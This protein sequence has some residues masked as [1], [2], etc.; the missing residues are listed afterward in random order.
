MIDYEIEAAAKGLGI[1]ATELTTKANDLGLALGVKDLSTCV[2]LLRGYFDA[3]RRQKALGTIHKPGLTLKQMREEL[4]KLERALH[5]IV[6]DRGTTEAAHKSIANALKEIPAELMGQLETIDVN[7]K[8]MPYDSPDGALKR[9]LERLPN[10]DT[11]TQKTIAKRLLDTVKAALDDLVIPG[12]GNARKQA[13]P[14]IAGIQC[15]ITHFQETL[16]DRQISETDD[17][18]FSRYVALW[19]QKKK[20]DDK[21]DKL[22]SPRRHIQ[23]AIA[24]LK[25]WKKISL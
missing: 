4:E 2:K 6:D 1:T 17:S 8:S 21:D 22:E 18:T 20:K 12:K 7:I 23:S 5:K 15:L 19:I 3:N 10:M 16:P 25:R 9:W 14:Y 13:H 11:D 24:D